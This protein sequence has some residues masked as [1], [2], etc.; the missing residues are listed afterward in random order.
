MEPQ[1]FQRMLDQLKTDLRV[2]LQEQLNRGFAESGHALQE[3]L[4]ENRR[5]F[6]VVAE[7]LLSD[8]RLV[9]EGVGANT[10]RIADFRSEVQKEL[11][12]VKSMIRLSHFE[13]DRR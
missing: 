7:D 2:D 10:E 11:T 12:E 3:G 5:H 9:A 4:A 8:L 6:N 13:L 1:T